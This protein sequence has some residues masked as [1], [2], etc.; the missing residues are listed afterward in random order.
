MKISESLELHDMF[1]TLG[2]MAWDIA[3]EKD[4]EERKFLY[5]L[6][7]DHRHLIRLMVDQADRQGDKFNGWIDFKFLLYEGMLCHQDVYH[8]KDLILKGGVTEE[9]WAAQAKEYARDWPEELT[10]KYIDGYN[11]FIEKREKHYAKNR[12][13]NNESKNVDKDTK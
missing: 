11:K 4:P 6:F 10:N 1:I 13:E 8:F 3:D 9:E 2:E 5:E 7:E 12:E